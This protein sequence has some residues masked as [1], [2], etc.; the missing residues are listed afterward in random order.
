MNTFS[1]RLLFGALVLTAGAQIS[2]ADPASTP[3]GGAVESTRERF[4]IEAQSVSRALRRYAEQTG[5]QVVYFS[6]VGKG[7]E[8][9]LVA[10]NYTRDQALRIL[11]QNTGLTYQRLNPRTVAISRADATGAAQHQRTAE[12]AP[13]LRLAQLDEAQLRL[14]SA[15]T[16][17][18]PPPPA[19]TPAEGEPRAT[20]VLEEVVVTGTARAEGVSKLNA[21][22]AITTVDAEQIRELS[23]LS[24]ADLFKVTPGVWAESSGGES[25]ANV[26]VR[27]FA[28]AG[29]AQYATVQYAGSPI[30]PPS[31]LSFLENSTL[32]RVDETIHHVEALRGN[33][34]PVFSNG[35]PGVTF[36]FI[37]KK[38]TDVAEGL[39]KVSLSDYGLKRT[40]V[41]YGGPLAENWA[42]A[43]GGF[44]RTSDGIRD[45][46]FPA[47]EGGQFSLNLTRELDNGEA[48]FY[49][50]RTEDKN[51]FITG[52]PLIGS[53]SGDNVDEFS[54]FNAG[55]GFYAGNET[56]LALLEVEAAA[57]AGGPPGTQ[58]VDL[59]DGRGIDIT[60]AGGSFDLALNDTW[61]FG[62]KFSFLKGDANTRA[63]FNQGPPV[64]IEDFIDATITAANAS[65]YVTGAAGLATAGTATF[66]TSASNDP[67]AA[68]QQVLSVGWWSVDK[69]L[70]S[71]TTD[72]RLS[73]E[74]G[75]HTPTIGLYYADYSSRDLWY[76][77]NNTVLTAEPN[78]RLVDIVLDNGV[79]VTRDGFGGTAPG[80][81]VP[82]F[83]VNASYNGRNTALFL[84]DEVILTDQLRI[85]LGV[86]YEENEVN[87]SLENSVAPAGGDFDGDPLTYYN[88]GG[89]V[90][91]GAFRA[92]EFDG[93]EVSY[94][95]GA[96]YAF[97][98][99]MAVFVRVNSGHRF[100]F[101]DELR[102]G[103][104]DV[105]DIE[106]YEVGFKAA[107][108]S[109]GLY[110]T[111]FYLELDGQ[112]LQAFRDVDG[113]GIPENINEAAGGESFGVEIEAEYYLLDAIA[114]NLSATLQNAELVDVGAFTGNQT[115]RQPEI[116][117]RFTP[118]YTFDLPWG[119]IKVYT[120][121]T[122]VDERFQDN[123]NLQPLPQ[124]EKV[125]AGVSIDVGES[126][127]VLIVGDNLTDEIAVTEGNPRVTGTGAVNN[128]II[129]RPIQGRSVLASMTYRF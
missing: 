68:G 17:A 52:I 22:F 81:G 5:D 24:T 115:P 21:S 65:A 44:Y 98:D 89:A 114:L 28:V 49:V 55:T 46:Q 67:L 2:A 90:L 60:L 9:S 33:P 23:P 45:S 50:R 72:V 76:L 108:D 58:R 120:T 11:L 32:F 75:R 116:Q 111:G 63:L 106:Q 25:G 4:D 30:Y 125:D 70:E 74:L 127:N 43:V 69:A 126:F 101:F 119:G 39:A 64:S 124:Y 109:W 82:F 103:I 112:N 62:T 35:Q 83:D 78:S 6:E 94:T 18:P 15:Q 118:S 10:G 91:G 36:N 38:G 96:N 86:R 31:T 26:M 73:A 113:D 105:V 1:L 20:I 121:L 87:A 93:D 40:D 54:G 100:P 79:L 19:G 97:T 122:Y 3:G 99:R 8:S 13:L 107:G 53:T 102:D 129:A 48:S 14:A 51:L 56:R 29:D 61:T 84:A 80:A 42:I 104:F 117:A 41:F 71:F 92:M 59:G 7:R 88:N 16:E 110:A 85:D 47:D 66:A 27:G 57:T 128:V 37:P 95:A 12:A 34:N 123:A 77:G